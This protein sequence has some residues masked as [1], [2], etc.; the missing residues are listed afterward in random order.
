MTGRCSIPP[1]PFD[2]TLPGT[3]LTYG[4]NPDEPYSKLFLIIPSNVSSEYGFFQ[5]WAGF[6]GSL[7]WEQLLAYPEASA[8]ALLWLEPTGPESE[9]WA[10]ELGL[11]YRQALEGRGLEVI[12]MAEDPHSGL[13]LLVRGHT[14]YGL[15]LPEA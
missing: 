12:P 6:G 1:P 13:L 2:R 5:T 9:T 11:A 4:H 3:S 15:L 10:L 14:A 7:E 8:D